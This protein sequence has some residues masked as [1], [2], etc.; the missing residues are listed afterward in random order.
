MMADYKLQCGAYALGLEYLTG[1]KPA[2]AFIVVARRIGPP[3]VTFMSQDEL[4]R[5]QDGY[6]LRCSLFYEQLTARK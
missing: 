6:L 3:N 5:A 2:G 4:V 1:I